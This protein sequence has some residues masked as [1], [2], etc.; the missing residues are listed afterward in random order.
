MHFC[1]A[2]VGVS[3]LDFS[4]NPKVHI[5]CLLRYYEKY[6]PDVI[7]ISADTWVTAQAVGA[8]VHSPDSNQPLAGPSDGFIHSRHDLDRIPHASQ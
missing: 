8:P 4:L 7:W 5:E 1:A 6:E 3:F 2:D